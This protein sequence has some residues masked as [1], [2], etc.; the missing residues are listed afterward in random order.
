VDCG[1]KEGVV[2]LLGSSFGQG[3][4]REERE[5]PIAGSHYRIFRVQE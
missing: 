5:K 1:R 4:Y 3:I 2:Y